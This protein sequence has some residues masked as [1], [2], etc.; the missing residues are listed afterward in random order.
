MIHQ[1]QP[2]LRPS[3]RAVAPLLVAVGAWAHEHRAGGPQQE[4]SKNL[5]FGCLGSC[6]PVGNSSAHPKGACELRTL[7][8]KPKESQ[9]RIVTGSGAT[10]GSV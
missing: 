8:F 10:V 4:E 3:L 9:I 6:R 1:T 2:L 7:G 5:G